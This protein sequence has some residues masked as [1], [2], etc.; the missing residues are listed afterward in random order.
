M[1]SATD[2]VAHRLPPAWRQWTFL[3][4][5]LVELLLQCDH[6]S[7]GYDVWNTSM[8]P[9]SD[10]VFYNRVNLIGLCKILLNDG[11][12]CALLCMFSVQDLDLLDQLDNTVTRTAVY[13]ASTVSC[14]HVSEQQ[15]VP[16]EDIAELLKNAFMVLGFPPE[17]AEKLSPLVVEIRNR[18]TIPVGF[19]LRIMDRNKS[20]L[21]PA[22]ASS[23]SLGSHI[24]RHHEDIF[25]CG[26][27]LFD[28]VMDSASS[29]MPFVARSVKQ[30]LMA[31]LPPS[32]WEQFSPQSDA[33]K[34]LAIQL[35]VAAR[36]AP[37]LKLAG[38][39]NYSIPEEVSEQVTRGLPAA[40]A[41]PN[42]LRPTPT[43]SPLSANLHAETITLTINTRTSI[44][45]NLTAHLLTAD[46]FRHEIQPLEKNMS[47]GDARFLRDL[48]HVLF[49]EWQRVNIDESFIRTYCSKP[50]DDNDETMGK[51]S[52]P[53]SSGQQHDFP[54]LLSSDEKTQGLGSQQSVAPQ[55]RPQFYFRP[56]GVPTVPSI[57]PRSMAAQQLAHEKILLQRIAR[58]TERRRRMTGKGPDLLY[59]YSDSKLDY[60]TQG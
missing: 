17:C 45:A 18:I 36:A 8:D 28:L 33:R 19:V 39:E 1:L 60:V 15:Q 12:V 23:S 32:L 16:T 42:S 38:V 59:A 56:D 46:D 24:L 29:R 27:H 7:F 37:I 4:V 22:S 3:S 31:R 48:T 55:P 11:E 54:T 40:L 35:V 2:A 20:T 57:S 43:T 49:S 52:I 53:P 58:L 9:R 5:R 25:L 50:E 51:K 10:R 6:L 47:A 13:R 14:D 44:I 26:N 41:S 34:C 21:V 30:L